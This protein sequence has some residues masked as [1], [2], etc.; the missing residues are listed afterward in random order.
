[1]RGRQCTIFGASATHTPA[2]TGWLLVGDNAG[3][4]FSYL[5]PNPRAP[6]K[7]ERQDIKLL[8]GRS[9]PTASLT[10]KLRYHDMQPS[11]AVPEPDRGVDTSYVREAMLVTVH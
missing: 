4:D 2:L 1:M 5:Q 3:L 10:A 9:N 8:R 11:S 7:K 6:P